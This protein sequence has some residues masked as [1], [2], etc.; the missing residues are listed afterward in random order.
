MA[1]AAAQGGTA[2]RPG[3]A[4]VNSTSGTSLPIMLLAVIALFTNPGPLV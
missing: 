1:P 3:I 4:A 2:A